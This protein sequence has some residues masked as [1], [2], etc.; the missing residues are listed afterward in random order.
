MKRHKR[1]IILQRKIMDEKIEP[2]MGLRTLFLRPRDGWLKSVRQSLGLSAENLAKR[3][4]VSTASVLKSENREVGGKV[5]LEKIKELADAMECEFVYAIIP[6]A[7]RTSFQEIID[8]L[9]LVAA[10]KIVNRVSHTMALEDQKT[11]SKAKEQE[12]LEFAEN[13]KNSTSKIIWT[14]LEKKAK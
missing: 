5:T 9:S 2:L 11:E 10:Q 3:L 1:D 4:N 6:K 8:N 14:A 13:L 7:P 12:I